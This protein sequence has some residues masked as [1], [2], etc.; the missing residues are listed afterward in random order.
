MAT[1]NAR[2]PKVSAVASALYPAEWK[3]LVCL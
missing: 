2:T 1:K 3:T